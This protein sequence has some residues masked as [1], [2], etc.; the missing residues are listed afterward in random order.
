MCYWALSR[1]TITR[2]QS[3]VELVSFQG[4]HDQTV[5]RE[6]LAREHLARLDLSFLLRALLPA[7]F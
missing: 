7:L 6:R 4:A 1:G 5:T 2:L 3:A